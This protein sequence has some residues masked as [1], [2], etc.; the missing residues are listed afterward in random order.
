MTR[1]KR[2]VEIR[3]LLTDEETPEAIIAASTGIIERLPDA[4][5]SRIAK[6]MGM[7]NDDPDTALILFNAGLNDVYDWADYS[8]VWLA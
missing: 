5:T 1:W 4:P 3:D 8:R 2:K 7:A 6:A